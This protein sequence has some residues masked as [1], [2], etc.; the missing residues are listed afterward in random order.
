MAFFPA[1][2][3]FGGLHM[4]LEVIEMK[5]QNDDAPRSGCDAPRSGCDAKRSRSDA[6]RSGCDAKR[7]GCDATRSGC[8][9]SLSAEDSEFDEIME[10][11]SH[12]EEI[13]SN[14]PLSPLPAA[15]L[16]FAP[17]PAVSPLPA[18]MLNFAFL[19]RSVPI[20]A[21]K[22][23]ITTYFTDD[24]KRGFEVEPDIGARKRVRVRSLSAGEYSSVRELRPRS[25]AAHAAVPAITR[26]RRSEPNYTLSDVI[27]VDMD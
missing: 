23:P 7:S 26:R 19:E 14:P 22:V 13:A 8:D 17:E 15:M 2:N 9:A 18:A 21:V 3:T 6:T 16:N 5:R 12:W 27:Y 1:E 10:C 4:L 11:I 24:K 25:V 20:L